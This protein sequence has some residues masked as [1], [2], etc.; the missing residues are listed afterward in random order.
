LTYVV[1]LI[2][3]YV[4]VGTF[5]PKQYQPKTLI[6]FWYVLYYISYIKMKLGQAQS[7][8]LALKELRCLVVFFLIRTF[9]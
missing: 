6:T 9:F 2:H 8:I 3:Y 5:A 1:L 7:R 4:A